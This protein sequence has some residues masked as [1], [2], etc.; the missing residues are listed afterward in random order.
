M[1]PSLNIILT[2]PSA[3]LFFLAVYLSFSTSYSSALNHFFPTFDCAVTR[4]LR[5]YNVSMIAFLVPLIAFIASWCRPVLT[6]SIFITAASHESGTEE[7]LTRKHITIFL[8]IGILCMVS[9]SSLA[10]S[11]VE[12]ISFS[13]LIS[14]GLTLLFIEHRIVATY[15]RRV[16]SDPVFYVVMVLYGATCLYA[17]SLI[18]NP[19]YA[20]RGIESGFYDYVLDIFNQQLGLVSFGDN[21]HPTP[22]SVGV[23][24]DHPAGIS[25]LQLKFFEYFGADFWTWRQSTTWIYYLTIFPLYLLLR[26][27][28]DRKT[29]LPGVLLF[30]T[31]YY[32]FQ[33]SKTGY[34]N[35]HYVVFW[36]TG[37]WLINIAATY[38]SKALIF[39]AAVVLSLAAYINYIGLALPFLGL[40]TWVTVSRGLSWPLSSKKQFLLFMLS[41]IAIA[42][43][44]FLSHLDQHLQLFVHFSDP[45]KHSLGSLSLAQF[46]PS[47]VRIENLLFTGLHPLLYAE[48]PLYYLD[49][50][51]FDEISATLLLFGLFHFHKALPK[52]VARSL[53]FSLAAQLALFIVVM[54]YFNRYDHPAFTRMFFFIPCVSIFGAIGLRALTKELSPALGTIT[55]SLMLIVAGGINYFQLDSYQAKWGL[56][57]Y[58]FDIASYLAEQNTEYRAPLSYIDDATSEEVRNT[59]KE[60]EWFPLKRAVQVV[61]LSSAKPPVLPLD[62]LYNEVFIGYQAPQIELI[63]K[64]LVNFG[65]RKEAPLNCAYSRTYLRYVR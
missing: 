13:L 56:H 9:S 21:F 19:E 32:G 46:L 42:L 51:L 45:L 8:L 27:I 40:L 12:L 14:S 23:Y 43:F 7:R 48:C 57:G 59:E 62:K 28:F 31:S 61:A 39:L 20:L 63:E 6:T 53:C 64:Q 47:F 50:K 35:I 55:A 37:M 49:G 5:D 41:G 3:A 11:S 34:N 1:R 52:G 26:D 16:V 60:A 22:W 18:Q 24:G 10:I 29:A 4:M 65:Y 54:G 36:I 15:V 2:L 33:F 58:C 30:V 17:T 25:F 44:P 38:Q